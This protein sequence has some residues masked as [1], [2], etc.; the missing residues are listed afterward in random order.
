[1]FFEV[2]GAFSG[3]VR[4]FSIEDAGEFLESIS[5][6]FSTLN[7]YLPQNRVIRFV[8]YGS[9]V[10]GLMS[11]APYVLRHT[12][13][14]DYHYRHLS[15]FH[16]YC[17][18]IDEQKREIFNNMIQSYE[19]LP[20]YDDKFMVVEIQAGGGSNLLYYPDNTRLIAVDHD[21]KYKDQMSLNFPDDEDDKLM[22]NVSLERFICSHPEQ[23]IG[24][25]DG[26]ISAI[27]SVHSLCYPMN[28][29]HCFEEFKRVLMPGGRIYFIEHAQETNFFS[30][31][32]FN[33]LRF[34]FVFAL[35]RCHVRRDVEKF[36]RRANFS[37][38]KIDRFCLNTEEIATRPLQVLAPH[39]YG[40]AI[41]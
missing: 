1:M 32:Y 2:L 23:L 16:C 10:I 17:P 27:V 6:F 22:Q 35:V 29:D 15:Y 33:Q 37:F 9:G 20:K 12:E 39:I 13:W 3:V 4:A 21:E 14:M 41:K 34:V 40:Y 7:S 18:L 31:A 11:L 28:L 36:L 8:F 25:P 38:L 26:T 30:W 19:E 24:V 5:E